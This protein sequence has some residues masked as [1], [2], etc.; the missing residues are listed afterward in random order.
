MTLSYVQQLEDPRVAPFRNLPDSH[1]GREIGPLFIAEGERLLK[2]MVRAGIQPRSVLLEPQM[3]ARI[4]DLLGPDVK[5]LVCHRELLREIVGFRFHRGLLALAERPAELELARII[6]TPP[7]RATLV[8][9]DGVQDPE[10]LGSILRTAAAFGIDAVLIGK[11]SCDPF[12]RR[13]LRV[14]IGSV[15]RLP[16]RRCEN[17]AADLRRL[18]QQAGFEI[19]AGVLDSDAE[20][21]GSAFHRA[22]RLALVLGSEADGLRSEVL[23]SCD[24]RLTI[25]LPG[26]IDSLNVSVAAGILLHELTARQSGVSGKT[27]FEQSAGPLDQ[28][29]R[30]GRS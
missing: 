20:P 15:F 6:H 18:Q 7:R 26:K 29:P 10:N 9:C 1:A 16:V 21:I 25:P 8:A 5:R 17:L 23:S 11:P 19:A 13:V 4:S 28:N 12:S 24:R 30:A 2:R 22:S 3:V 14:S 27:A